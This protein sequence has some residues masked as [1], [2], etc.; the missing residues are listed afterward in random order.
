MVLRTEVSLPLDTCRI[1][2]N[3]LGS[4]SYCRA[5]VNL[6]L[7]WTPSSDGAPPGQGLR[8]LEGCSGGRRYPAMA[9]RLGKKIT[10]N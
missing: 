10:R 8:E 4:C 6:G 9:C 1:G 7:D 3:M 2:A 5:A